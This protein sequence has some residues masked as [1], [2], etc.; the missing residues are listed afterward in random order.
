M[1][2]NRMC[3]LDS[4]LLLDLVTACVSSRVPVQLDTFSSFMS[5]CLML[6]VSASGLGHRQNAAG[7]NHQRL[8][9]G[10]SGDRVREQ[11]AT[12]VQIHRTT[13]FCED[14][15]KPR[16]LCAL[17]YLHVSQYFC[18]SVQCRHGSKPAGG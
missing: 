6:A 10:G 5:L 18:K 9:D 11:N 13:K 17:I 3:V 15:V 12:F 8:L 4:E 14:E 7:L 16:V 1:P 2:A